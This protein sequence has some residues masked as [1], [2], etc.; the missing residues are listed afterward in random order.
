MTE[1]YFH[2]DLRGP[3]WG[4]GWV[5]PGD[6]GVSECRADYRLLSRPVRFVRDATS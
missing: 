4:W 1:Y 6:G 3:A 5:V 2:I